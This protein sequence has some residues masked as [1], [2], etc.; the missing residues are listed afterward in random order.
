MVFVPQ[1]FNIVVS[2]PS[3]C[4]AEP[5]WGLPADSTLDFVRCESGANVDDILVGTSDS[6]YIYFQAKRQLS[7]S[8][9]EDSDFS[10]TLDQFTRQYLVADQGQGGR[11]NPWNRPFDSTRDRLVLLTSSE[12]SSPIRIDFETICRR[13][14][15]LVAGQ[16]LASVAQTETETSTLARAREHIVRSWTAIR[17]IAPSD[18]EVRSLLATIYVQ[19]LDVE[20]GGTHETAAKDNLWGHVLRVPTQADLAWRSLISVFT[21]VSSI[22]SGLQRGAL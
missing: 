11:D 3:R 12:S 15:R 17:N 1:V 20:S 14:Q 13:A 8:E 18:E 7:V 5:L 19:V 16:A 6:E 22:R 2:T 21:D 9:R 4:N 10:S